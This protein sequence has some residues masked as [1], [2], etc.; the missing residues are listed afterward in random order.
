MIEREFALSGY[1]QNPR[2]DLA[3]SVRRALAN[4]LGSGAPRRSRRSS[5]TASTSSSSRPARPRPPHERAHRR[6][7]ERGRGTSSERSTARDREMANPCAKDPRIAAIRGARGTCRDRLSRSPAPGSSIERGPAD[8]RAPVDPTRKTLGG[9]ETGL[10]GRVSG[11][12]ASRCRPVRRRRVAGFG[13]G[14]VHGYARS[15]ARSSGAACQR[16][17]RQDA[18]WRGR[19]GNQGPPSAA[20]MGPDSPSCPW[21]RLR[22]RHGR[23]SGTAP[24][25]R[26]KRGHPDSP[27]RHPRRG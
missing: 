13:G 17:Q 7:A 4:R 22:Q 19:S 5:A 1:E 16:A 26:A 10:S 15:R 27:H 14:G 6:G 3:R 9:L 23:L 21:S 24:G 12:A 2:P 25:R 8:R 18:R 11:R 20:S